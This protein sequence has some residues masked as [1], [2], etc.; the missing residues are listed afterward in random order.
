[1]AVYASESVYGNSTPY[2]KYVD[3]RGEKIRLGLSVLCGTP[4][5][6][7]LIYQ[8]RL[9]G[10][11]S[12]DPAFLYE[13]RFGYAWDFYMSIVWVNST[14]CIKFLAVCLQPGSPGQTRGSSALCQPQWDPF[15]L[16]GY[17]R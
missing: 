8:T 13:S 5:L 2:V 4:G 17:I 14:V 15:S 1:M 10:L 11:S 9:G 12:A 16:I 3:K 6:I 7:D